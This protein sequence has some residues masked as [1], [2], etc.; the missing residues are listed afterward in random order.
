MPHRSFLL[1]LTA[2]GFRPK[3]FPREGIG[4][5]RAGPADV[6]RCRALWVEVG[7][8]YWTERSRWR[9]ARWSAHLAYS[10]VSFWIASWQ[11][12][13]IGFFE[14]IKKRQGTKIE[15]MGLLPAWCG[16]GLGGGLLSAAT[17]QALDD[18]A[19]R[20]WLHTA[21]DDHPNALPNYEARGYRVYRD[22]PLQNPMPPAG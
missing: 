16:Q 21:T 10:S 7:R 3:A 1:Q 20:V 22:K 4:L 14:L 6:E 2:E 8:G 11:A 18:G 9:P 15:G 13:D 12:R 19:R 17:R 5:A